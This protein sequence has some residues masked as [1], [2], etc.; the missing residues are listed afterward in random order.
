[1]LAAYGSLIISLFT[2][3]VAVWAWLIW[4]WIAR[5]PILPRESRQDV[6][7]GV[8]DLL[9]TVG[10]YLFLSLAAVSLVKT[11]PV[12]KKEV[13]AEVVLENT[14]AEPPRE[15]TLGGAQRMIAL[16]SVVKLLTLLIVV[17]VITMRVQPL[18]TDWGWTLAEIS[19]D[20][21]VGALTFL[22][23]FLPMI[24]LQSLLV[25]VFEWK[26][27]HPLIELVT[28]TKD[29]LLFALAGIAAAV[30]APLFEEFVF[31]G[32]LQ[33]WLEKLLGGNA[34]KEMIVAGGREEPEVE[35]Y[36]PL[37]SQNQPAMDPNPY[38]APT[39]P[40]TEE[41]FSI[42]WGKSFTPPSPRDWL[43]IVI[44]TVAFSLLH[45]SHGPAWIPLLIFGAATGF[46]YQRTHRL[47][48]GVVVHVLLNTTTMIGLWVQ[49]FGK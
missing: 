42:K 46:V 40:N 19:N 31:R 14:Q 44:S 45:Y 4:R 38:A 18:A 11:E 33:G 13:A 21:R 1:M 49:V 5:L 26:Y 28:E 10:L 48:P 22:A 20:V 9:L 8:V 41:S 16:D 2:G 34:S 7:W 3:G 12:P 32:L 27:E 37:V 15:F 30:V 6:P 17:V 25:V 29:P 39:V 43:A 47:W 24:T 36:A 23:I 35:I